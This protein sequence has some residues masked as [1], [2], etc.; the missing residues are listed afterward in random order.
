MG[1]WGRMADVGAGRIDFGKILQHRQAAGL[2]H[3]YV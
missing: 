1:R 2:R 3:F